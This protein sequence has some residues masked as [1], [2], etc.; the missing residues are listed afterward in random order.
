MRRAN[1]GYGR[2]QATETSLFADGRIIA[3]AMASASGSRCSGTATQ[4]AY[5]PPRGS[6]QPAST[7]AA[8]SDRTTALAAESEDG[9]SPPFV[10]TPPAASASDGRPRSTDTEAP[11]SCEFGWARLQA[12]RVS[13]G[14]DLSRDVVQLSVGVACHR[15][16]GLDRRLG[17]EP[18]LGDQH[19]GGLLHRTTPVGRAHGLVEAGASVV[20]PSGEH[21]TE[22][23][24]LAR[25][26]MEHG[27]LG[28]AAWRL[29]RSFV[30]RAIPRRHL[31]VGRP[32]R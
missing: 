22:G 6:S 8:L 26:Q 27:V 17:V 20:M 15:H 16:D 10:G 11:N 30:R 28:G 23:Y 4:T 18:A 24:V 31:L 19:A 13:G 3:I 12:A 9:A 5:V 29:G 25:I 32:P 2:A 7:W 21:P 14:H 1:A